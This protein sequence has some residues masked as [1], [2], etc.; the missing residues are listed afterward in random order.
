VASGQI[1]NQKNGI[2]F[3]QEEAGAREQDFRGI[4]D[5]AELE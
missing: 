4:V 1:F 5:Q 3:K 2:R